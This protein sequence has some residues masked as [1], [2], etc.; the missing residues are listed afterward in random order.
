[1]QPRLVE[2]YTALFERDVV[3]GGLAPEVPLPVLAYAVVRLGESF[4]Y[5]DVMVARE[6]DLK[7]AT[8]VVDALVTGVLGV[9]AA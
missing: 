2:A 6:P 1:V 8:T 5:S 9:R 3:D 4:L 7:A